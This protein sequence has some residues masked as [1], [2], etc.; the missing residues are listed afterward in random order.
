[1]IYDLGNHQWNIPELRKLIED[2]LPY[3]YSFQDYKAK[4]VFH[5]LGE[6]I[7]LLNGREI[8]IKNG[9]ERLILLAIEDITEK[10]AALK[11][12][13]ER[14]H[15]LK[16]QADQIIEKNIELQKIN[17]E[18]EAFNYVSSHD[19]QEPLRKIQM[20]AGRILDKENQN[21]SEKGKEMFHRMQEASLRME[22]LIQDLLAFARTNTAERKFEIVNL[23]ELIEELKFEFKE[24]IEEKNAI[25]EV[26]DLCDAR[27]IRFQFRQLMHNLISNALKFSKPGVPP[28][29][30]IKNKIALGSELDNPKLFPDK[31]YC[32]ITVTDNGIGFEKQYSEK[33]FE[34]FQKLHVKE[35]YPGT[36]IGL[37]IVKKIVENH[38]GFIT[39]HSEISQGARFDI[40]I[41]V[42]S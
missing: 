9:D 8:K 16:N 38:T 36:G 23:N 29:I 42:Q 17:K 32:H 22:T 39:A 12:I 2:I 20:F 27:L 34:V 18:L 28:H 11:K 37:A 13:E 24:K 7:M 1:L 31:K 30:I 6:R 5:A 25:I 10:E 4:Q 41:P 3:Q 14:E 40:Y 33:I 15:E 19:L 26:S 35:E 21:L